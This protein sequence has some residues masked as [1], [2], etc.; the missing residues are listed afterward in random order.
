MREN[1]SHGSEGGESRKALL[2]PYTECWFEN[3]V[4]RYRY[5]ALP[6]YELID[7]ADIRIMP[8]RMSDPRNLRAFRRGYTA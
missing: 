1:R 4:I 5:Y 3:G 6:F 2:Y 7:N 8:R